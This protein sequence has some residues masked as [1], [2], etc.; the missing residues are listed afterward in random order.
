[1]DVCGEELMN[2]KTLLLHPGTQYS[3]RLACQLNR[4][5]YLYKFITGIAITANDSLLKWLPDII[6]TKISNRILDCSLSAEQVK[7]IPVPELLALFQ[8]WRGKNMESVMHQRNISFQR[9]I[10]RKHIETAECFIGFDTSSWILAEQVTKIKK[11]FFLDQS[12][13]HPR[14]KERIYADLRTNYPTWAEGIQQKEDRY[15]HVEE[16]EYAL[17]TRIVVASS[18]TKESLIRQGVTAEKICMNPYGVSESFFRKRD[19]PERK[20]KIRFLYLG[21]L[22][23]RKGL[24]FLLETWKE[25]ELHCIA[26]LWLAGPASEDV[27]LIVQSIEGVQYKGKIPFQQMPTLIKECDSLVFP[28][29]FEGFGQVILEAMAG[30]LPVI[31]TDATAGPDIIE[32]GTDGLLIRAGDKKSLA[33][34]MSRLAHDPS[35][36]IEMGARAVEKAQSFSW[37]AYGDRWKRIILSC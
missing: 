16:T 25:F 7:S 11:P 28:S 21:L 9:S 19:K 12:I 27:Q 32:N 4:V 6:R 31:T 17:A 30:G 23:V 13:A 20:N 26:E 37:D 5:G 35:L 24:P 14:E 36:C 18:F 33:E 22:G 1:M 15:I 3:H 10:P 8:L 2:V 29:F 34:N